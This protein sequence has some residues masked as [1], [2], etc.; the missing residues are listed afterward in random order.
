MMQAENWKTVKATLLE[1]LKLDPSGRRAYLD[2]TNLSAEVRAEVES[3]LTHE[4]S[5]KDF[6]SV[7]ASGYTREF[8]DGRGL[9]TN[10]LINQKI[11]IYEIVSELGF[12]GMG[13]VYLAMRR[14]GQFEQKVAIKMLKREF[15]TEKTRQTFKREKEI[16][17]ALSHPNIAT[18]LDAGTS[19]D[20]IPYLVMEYIE[21][22]PIDK[23]CQDRQ[24][25]LNSRLKLFNK[26][27]D[28]V[29]L[30][31]RSLIV[32]R[33]LKPS[34]ILVTK[35]GEPK[36][37]D[38]GISKLLDSE[39]EDAGAV[40]H[41]GAMTPLY[42]SPEQIKGEPVTTSTDVY[43]LGVVLFKILTGNLPYTLAKTSNGNLLK[44]LTEAAPTLPSEVAKSEPP[45]SA[46][47][48]QPRPH[49]PANAGGSDK[50]SI[51]PSELRGDL[52]NIVL[53]ALR[54][55][56][57]RRYQTVEQFSA[58][59]W[60]FV[61]GMPVLARPATL[62]YRASKF[63][64]RNKVAV[65]AAILIVVSLF[66]GIA[67]ALSQA[68]TAR[69]QARIA[70]QERDAARRAGERAERTSRFMQSFLDYANPQ[71]FGRGKGRRDVTVREAIDDAATRID[72]ELADLPEVRADLHYTIGL[73]YASHD[74]P[75]AYDRHMR[76][77]LELYRQALGEEHP[78]V[79]RALYYV[80]MSKLG[81][82]SDPEE[83]T[84]PLR[85]GIAMMRKTGPDNVN[86]PYML[87]T[88]AG[89]LISKRPDPG[90]D[91]FAEAE[92]LL[93]EAKTLFTH[94][95]GK[96][97]GST[98]SADVNLAQLERKRGNLEK[99]E[100]IF[101]ECIARFRSVKDGGHG[102]IWSLFELGEVTRELGKAREAESLFKQAEDAGRKQWRTD[103]SQFTKLATALTRARAAANPHNR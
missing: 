75:Q 97:H 94:H 9:S 36:L 22:E 14:D 60:R 86:L 96:E 51:S 6:M 44:E 30:A 68:K 69:E 64:G 67:A 8:F 41:L 58:D 48:S 78:K 71:W 76:E 70:E 79:A 25:S 49:P 7:T 52:A 31:H 82:G 102:Y 55:E 88:L 95:Y 27:C 65:M 103:D 1:A 99:A 81:N 29:S 87:Q 20:G 39:A 57:P 33:D 56:P 32:H 4:D 19:D 98:V 100:S 13:V 18:L 28:T 34:N 16:L 38:F 10:A 74:D 90:P 93:A 53:K 77:S 17:A 12:G 15:N 26:V 50:S 66:L 92:N 46:G 72:T 37:L 73:V 80:A 40:T 59:I 85:Q 84:L 61:D 63:Y 5:A 101:R 2:N 11:G 83:S 62:R 43:S 42:A 3:L 35:D 47:G 89:R 21:G 54:K 45:A 23:F 91:G 24:L